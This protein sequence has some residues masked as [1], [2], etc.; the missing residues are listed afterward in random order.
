MKPWSY[1][2][3]YQQNIGAKS[4]DNLLQQQKNNNR[5]MQ[6]GGKSS[7]FKVKNRSSLE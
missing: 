5:K 1:F 6:N 3:I 4:E 2:P 7:V